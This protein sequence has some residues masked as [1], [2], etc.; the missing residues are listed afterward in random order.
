ML[1]YTR[2]EAVMYT[3]GEFAKMANVSIRTIRYYDK[4]NL[5]K[6]SKINDSGYRLYSDL[7]FVKLQKILSL[8]YLGFSLDEIRSITLHDENDVIESLELQQNLLKKKIDQLQ[9]V[10]KTL[11]E[12]LAVVRVDPVID[13][14]RI[15]KL[16]HVT[17]MQNALV[18]QYK[19]AANIKIR[20]D[21]HKRYAQNK[22]GWY[23]WIYEQL[24]LN[25]IKRVLEVGCGNGELWHVNQNKIPKRLELYLS[26]ISKG[27]ISDAKETLWE[28]KNPLTFEVIDCESI[29]KEDHMFDR[30]IAN[31]VLFY[32]EHLHQG[33]SEI[34]RVL[35]KDGV[36]FCTTYGREHMKEI[37][38]LVKEFDSRIV[39]SDIN[40]YDVFGLENAKE[41]LN[42]YFSSVEQ[43]CYEDQL[44]VTE[45]LP[46]MEYIL[47]CH[48]N[49][50]E[51]LSKKG[52]ITITKQAGGFI[53]KK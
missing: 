24:Q 39:L 27:M 14:N 20:I 22:V 15:L 2:G 43:V 35:K 42:P 25:G 53:C 48:G 51:L 41:L 30:V 45:S 17:N 47:S 34:K 44:K 49:Q 19:D 31:H 50:Q 7:D 4:Q 21:L 52:Y 10:E 32:V 6:P 16:I 8:K 11:E 18:D 1:Y 29:K 13:W 12:T 37:G 28:L 3:S 33:I 5:L 40:L 23:Q 38:Q 36:F 26:D 9:L 46:L